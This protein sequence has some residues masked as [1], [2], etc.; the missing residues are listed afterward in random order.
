MN[1]NPFKWPITIY[2]EDTDAGGVVYHSNYLKF[3][4]RARTELLRDKGVSQQVMLNESIGFVVKSLQIDFISA[5]R[6][7]EQLIVETL[8]TEIK[9]VSLTFCQILVNSD[10]KVLCKA[11]VKVACVDNSVMK[12]TAIPSF[13]LSE[14]SCDR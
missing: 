8:I 2:Y 11:T 9:K 7:D 5:A 13:I 10:G 3:F 14:I 4:E 12:P 6:L 1:M